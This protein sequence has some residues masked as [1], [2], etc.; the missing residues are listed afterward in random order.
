MCSWNSDEIFLTCIYSFLLFWCLY[1]F[2]DHWKSWSIG[3]AHGLV[4]YLICTCLLCLVR[5]CGFALPTLLDSP[6][7]CYERYKPWQWEIQ[8]RTDGSGLYSFLLI[9]VSTVPSGLFFTSYVF[10]AMS[11]T[12][13][14]DLLTNAEATFNA[15]A[16]FIAL[17]LIVW[18]SIL[19]LL[20]FAI[21]ESNYE[22][23][24]D[25]IAQI[26][27][28]LTALFTCFVFSFH[29]IKVP[30]SLA[31]LPKT[32]CPMHFHIIHTSSK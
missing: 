22:P 15:I 25:R 5:C 8:N 14:I 26:V 7:R 16:L 1:L 12:K 32:L 10:F 29:S 18:I 28:G 2:L 13:V 27:V 9:L 17:N 3:Q 4:W 23:L 31:T 19:L 21:F 11:L 24:V 6:T 30:S 20:G